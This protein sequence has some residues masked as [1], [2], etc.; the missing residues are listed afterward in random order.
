MSLA[1]AVSLMQPPRAP[2]TLEESGLSLGLLVQLSLKTLLFTGDL[3][4]SDLATRL[5][6]S[7]PVVAPALDV[8]KA[9]RQCE[10]S[11]GSMVGGA[12][13]RYRITDAGRARAALFL[14]Q[15]HY[16]GHAP[17]PFEHYRRYM[18]TFRSSSPRI[19]RA[20]V[21]D[22]FSHLVLTERVLDQIGPGCERRPFDVHLWSVG[23]R[24]DGHLAGDSESAPGRSLDPACARSRRQHHPPL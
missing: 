19:N 9:E 12:S 5:G 24:Q 8:L 14:E 4:G 2:E 3:T 16:V 22:A 23:K 20:A 11:G 17:V 15:N 13:Y 18:A 7:F 6:L 10:I 21:R 1:E